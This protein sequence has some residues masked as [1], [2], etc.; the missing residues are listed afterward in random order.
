MFVTFELL[1][2]KSRSKIAT[3]S[4]QKL[5]QTSN[6]TYSIFIAAS[7]CFLSLYLITH[8]LSQLRVEIPINLHQ[9]KF[10]GPL[11][12]QTNWK[13]IL[14]TSWPW[15][16]KLLQM[17]PRGLPWHHPM[18]LSKKTWLESK[19]WGKRH[20]TCTQRSTYPGD[21]K[22]EESRLTSI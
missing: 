16:I 1:C 13:T 15:R 12:K 14:L 7:I 4:Y 3:R 20:G 19:N 8:L 10:M 17:L 6:G 22:K 18:I 9:T 21:P 5:L 2:N 11:Q